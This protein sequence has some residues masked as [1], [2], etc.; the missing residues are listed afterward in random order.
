MIEDT[1]RMT[2]KKFKKTMIRNEMSKKDDDNHAHVQ[3]LW[4]KQGKNDNFC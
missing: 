3:F 2:K 1:E 4:R